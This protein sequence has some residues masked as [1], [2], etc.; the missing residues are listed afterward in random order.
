[1][2]D[3]VYLT[4]EQIRKLTL[5][6]DTLSQK[7]RETVRDLLKRIKGDG[8]YEAELHRELL[9]LRKEYLISEIDMKNIEQAIFEEG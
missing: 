8:I 4:D 9:K 1:M 3:K 2:A 5:F 6:I 7:E